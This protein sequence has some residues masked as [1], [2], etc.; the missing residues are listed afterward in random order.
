MD[1]TKGWAKKY[2]LLTTRWKIIVDLDPKISNHTTYNLL[3]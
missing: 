2:V 1:N 3:S